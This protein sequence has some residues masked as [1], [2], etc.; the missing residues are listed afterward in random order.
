MQ[1]TDPASKA[2]EANLIIF[3]GESGRKI[4]T[5]FD[6][7]RKEVDRKVGHAQPLRQHTGL[8]FFWSENENENS[9]VKAASYSKEITGVDRRL[10]YNVSLDGA[11]RQIF[12]GWYL[13]ESPTD[14]S[15]K[16][17]VRIFIV[18]ASHFSAVQRIQRKVEV[19]CESEASGDIILRTCYIPYANTEASRQVTTSAR[20]G[21][22]TIEA[23]P[24]GGK[25]VVEASDG[26]SVEAGTAGG[27]LVR[28]GE[29][30]KPIPVESEKT[31]QPG[32]APVMDTVSLPLAIEGSKK[33]E[34]PGVAAGTSAR[35]LYPHPQKEQ[36]S[37]ENISISVACTLFILLSTDLASEIDL[38]IKDQ[39]SGILHTC[40]LT[41]LFAASG[42]ENVAIFSQEIKNYCLNRI[43]KHIL[44]RW[45]DE[46]QAQEITE[47][48]MQALE[49]LAKT[50]MY[51][52][53]VKVSV[54]GSTDEPAEQTTQ[55]A[56]AAGAANL[57]AES[58]TAKTTQDAR[59]GTTLGALYY[60]WENIRAQPRGSSGLKGNRRKGAK[61]SASKD[62]ERAVKNAVDPIL[63]LIREI[64]DML[65]QESLDLK[66]VE[67]AIEQLWQGLEDNRPKKETWE[68]VEAA[69]KQLWK[70]MNDNKAKKGSA[71]IDEHSR[72]SFALEKAF[73]RFSIQDLQLFIDSL[74][75]Q[76][77]LDVQMRNA[78]QGLREN[79]RKMYFAFTDINRCLQAVQEELERQKKEVAG[80]RALLASLDRNAHHAHTVHVWNGVHLRK[81][82][83]EHMQETMEEFVR[84]YYIQAPADPASEP[85]K[86]ERE[87]KLKLYQY[88]FQW[89]QRGDDE[90]RPVQ[91]RVQDDLSEIAQST[92]N[93]LLKT[94]TALDDLQAAFQ[95]PDIWSHLF[96]H[97]HIDPP[98]GSHVFLCASTHKKL[99]NIKLPAQYDK[100]NVHMVPAENDQ[101][102]FVAVLSPDTPA[103]P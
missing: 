76:A 100:L 11:V 27:G 69:I 59:A 51:S 1:H 72:Q 96:Q 2:I 56:G 80:G 89:F 55:D 60:R 90:I 37:A 53:T 9:L 16:H 28:K 43:S 40:F 64:I 13:P 32:V 101:W 52:E 97:M 87:L 84:Q 91:K 92:L 31:E 81:D 14:S 30:A 62:A 12:R 99:V 85:D 88:L 25:V 22:V 73:I 19:V 83:G 78:T 15:R 54:P 77:G 94:T 29:K 58:M 23:K 21:S 33:T 74:T 65:W 98:A 17:T 70:V 49:K 6:E 24:V 45:I 39:H 42:E 86:N 36:P 67:T 10:A 7:I 82:N 34:Q 71:T 5:S 3:V 79:L 46:N 66:A 38:H 50:I 41:S 61:Q 18:A 103:A 102:F 44:D 95:K 4:F 47:P 93:S 57:D 8:I 20:T 63:K 48:V 75:G 68:A 26:L 35:Y